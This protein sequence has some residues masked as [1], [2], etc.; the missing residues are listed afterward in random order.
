MR[1]MLYIAMLGITV[2][3]CEKEEITIVEV[4][5]TPPTTTTTPTTEITG[6]TTTTTETATPTIEIGTTTPT[7]EITETTTNTVEITETTTNTVEITETTTTTTETQSET[8]EVEENDAPA[9]S[10]GGGS[11]TPTPSNDDEDDTPVV[12]PTQ[13][14]PV[15]PTQPATPV[16]TPVSEVSTPVVE[17]ETPVSEVVTPVIEVVTPVS[18]VVTPV[19]NVSSPVAEVETPAEEEVTFTCDTPSFTIDGDNYFNVSTPSCD[20]D[21]D[22]VSLDKSDGTVIAG[23]THANG[24]PV[25]GDSVA[26]A[27]ISNGDVLTYKVWASNVLV[28][29]T[30]ITVSGIPAVECTYTEA[31]S[32]NST[33]SVEDGDVTWDAL[34]SSNTEDVNV[35]QT[36][37]FIRTT[38]TNTTTTT[39]YT[40]S[41]SSCDDQDNL[42]ETNSV[43]VETTHST[44]RVVS[45][46]HYIAS[47]DTDG[48]S[49]G[50]VGEACT[51][52]ISVTYNDDSVS[53]TFVDG[54]DFN[55]VG[56]AITKDN[57][58]YGS[59]FSGSA[60]VENTYLS[61]GDMVVV[62]ANNG[63]GNIYTENI[64]I[65]GL[66]EDSS[67]SGDTG[68]AVDDSSDTDTDTDTDTDNNVDLSD[69]QQ[70]DDTDT[71][72]DTDT[73]ITQPTDL[74]NAQGDAE[75]CNM[76]INSGMTETSVVV[77]LTSWCGTEFSGASLSGGSFYSELNHGPSKP[78]EW[79]IPLNKWE[80]EGEGLADGSL[81]FTLNLLNPSIVRVFRFKL[82]SDGTY[83]VVN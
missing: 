10:G 21:W 54:C 19:S 33:T 11:S 2:L 20:G 29:S 40:K 78:V 62:T 80:E 57:I 71:D 25:F 61:N 17:V 74:G 44:S 59:S 5:Y 14:T 1:K 8:V 39:V 66:A 3:A 9:S 64:T 79:H 42:V 30:T 56:I 24:W 18:D 69:S 34:D 32:S 76:T 81:E 15:A 12:T 6:T 13:P 51:N 52:S 46:A 23:E 53:F 65:N 4:P 50:D 68:D 60:D 38:T 26:N 37:S 58:T 47:G 63:D 75:N 70:D 41:H 31:V 67:D 48:N 55:V 28:W 16:E 7:V 45:N 83:E 73:E 22:V 49:D 27:N 77:A 43:S 36:G 82:F 72:T 35:T